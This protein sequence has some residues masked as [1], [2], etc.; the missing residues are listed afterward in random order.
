MKRIL[1]LSNNNPLRIAK[2]QHF[3]GLSTQDHI[4]K[5]RRIH[6]FKYEVTA[7]EYLRFY[8]RNFFNQFR[9][10]GVWDRLKRILRNSLGCT[11]KCFTIKVSKKDNNKL[12]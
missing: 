1:K 6:R 9:R 4:F 7:I 3:K 10:K 11:C 12:T 5:F 2:Y 8:F